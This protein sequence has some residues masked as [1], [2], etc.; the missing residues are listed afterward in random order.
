MALSHAEKLDI[1][2]NECKDH[3][4]HFPIKENWQR[5]C[6]LIT[7]GDGVTTGNPDYENDPLLF[8]YITALI[9]EGYIS[10]FNNKSYINYLATV[11]GLTFEGFQNQST[12]NLQEVKNR[13]LQYLTNFLIVLIA[14]VGTAG[15][16]ILEIVKYCHHLRW[17]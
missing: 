17:E 12:R 3:Y 5:I 15:L 13:K 7:D 9:Q 1:I 4:G 14:S 8:A 6:R 16:L 10:K 11:K 2:L